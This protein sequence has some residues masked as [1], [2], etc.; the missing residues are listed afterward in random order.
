MKKIINISR[1]IIGLVIYKNDSTVKNKLFLNFK[2]SLYI[3]L[4][5]LIINIVLYMT[6]PYF[7]GVLAN[8]LK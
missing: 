8:F 4:F 5:V 2:N 1:Y 6:S 3:I 7:N